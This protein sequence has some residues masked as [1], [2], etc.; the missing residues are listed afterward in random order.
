MSVTHKLV[1]ITDHPDGGWSG[2]C[3]CNRWAQA[4]EMSLRKLRAK[5]AEHVREAEGGR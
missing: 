3:S 5:H 1:Q 2:N 4:G